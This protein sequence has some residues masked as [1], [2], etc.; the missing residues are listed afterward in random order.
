MTHS[1]YEEPHTV[2]DEA[3][4]PSQATSTPSTE[5]DPEGFG[6][7]ANKPSSS[8]KQEILCLVPNC[9]KGALSSAYEKVRW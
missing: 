4:S 2:A 6:T 8:Q 3:N 5:S 7:A 1:I 9:P